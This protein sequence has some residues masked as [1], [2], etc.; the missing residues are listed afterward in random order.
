MSIQFVTSKYS[1]VLAN[2]FDNKDF[3]QETNVNVKKQSVKL[4]FLR[5]IMGIH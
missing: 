4:S 2:S 3:F 5:L 1:N